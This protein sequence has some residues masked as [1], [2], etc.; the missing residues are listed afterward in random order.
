MQDKDLTILHNTMEADDLTSQGA[1][2]SAAE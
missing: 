1:R 2:A